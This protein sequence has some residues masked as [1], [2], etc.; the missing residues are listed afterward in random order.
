V[1]L[2]LRVGGDRRSPVVTQVP[3]SFGYELLSHQEHGN[4]DGKEDDAELNN[5]GR[6][7]PAGR[8]HAPFSDPCSQ[9]DDL[10]DQGSKH[11]FACGKLQIRVDSGY[12]CVFLLH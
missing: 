11:F 12:D 9:S 8:S 5:L 1:R 6:H 7:L 3:E 4:T 10:F 2:Q